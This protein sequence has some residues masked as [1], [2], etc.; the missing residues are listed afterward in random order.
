MTA[1]E[2]D[3]AE[4][5]RVVK[6]VAAAASRPPADPA[7]L[8]DDE[9]LNGEVLHLNSLSLVGVL[10]QVED[11]LDTELADDLFV[12]HSFATVADLAEVVARGRGAA[13]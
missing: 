10:V 2:P 7:A 12:G 3:R 6:K 1:T 8:R 13:A 4:I 5:T 11:E 9:P